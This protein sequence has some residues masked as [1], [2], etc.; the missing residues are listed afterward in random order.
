[1]Y[2]SG[3]FSCFRNITD[4]I[5]SNIKKNKT[6]I[7]ITVNIYDILSFEDFKQKLF[8]FVDLYLSP[9]K[10]SRKIYLSGRFYVRVGHGNSTP[11]NKSN[12]FSTDLT[13]STSRNVSESPK[14]SPINHR[15]SWHGPPPFFLT[16]YLQIY[17]K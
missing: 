2:N 5:A 9:D 8:L 11:L 14:I 10:L 4:T 17:F 15:R 6:I 16:F 3:Y 7:S 1:M 12:K 13:R